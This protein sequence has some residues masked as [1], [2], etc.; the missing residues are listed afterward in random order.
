[1]KAAAMAMVVAVATILVQEVQGR[2]V[3]EA[4]VPEG[5]EAG[6]L[7]LPILTDSSIRSGSLSLANSVQDLAYFAVSRPLCVRQIVTDVHTGVK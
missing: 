2:R 6:E 7:H 3:D 1:M 5:A 4:E